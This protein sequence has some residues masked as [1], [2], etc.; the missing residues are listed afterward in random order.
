VG[1]IGPLRAE[2][3]RIAVVE[4]GAFQQQR[5]GLG[6]DDPALGQT[7]GHGALH[8]PGG[9]LETDGRAPRSSSTREGQGRGRRQAGC[10]DREKA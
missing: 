1:G 7:V 6:V 8:E 10:E 9:A 2:P 3:H 5:A 4:A